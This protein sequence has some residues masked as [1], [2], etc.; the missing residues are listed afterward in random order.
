MSEL[1]E[2]GRIVRA[3]GLKGQ[4][5]V[6]LSTNRAER[7]APAALLSAGDRGHLRVTHS[8]RSTPTRARERW[9]VKFEGIDDRSAADTLRGAV[10]KAAPIVE[11][12]ALWVHELVGRK[13]FDLSGDSLGVVEAVEANPASDLLV[14]DNGKLIP[15]TFVVEATETGL[16]VDLPEGLLDL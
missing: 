13:V 2:V 14:L 16:K 9:L 1:L 15:L 4:V 8:S 12:D 3:H 10:L 6:E 7:V 5:V 11:P